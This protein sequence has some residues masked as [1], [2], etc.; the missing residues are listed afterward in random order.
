MVSLCVMGWGLVLLENSSVAAVAVAAAVTAAAVAAAAVA[1]GVDPPKTCVFRKEAKTY[2]TQSSFSHVQP[3][4]AEWHFF[5][6]TQTQH[7]KKRKLLA[8]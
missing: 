2:C 6:E 7:I 1:V 4:A 8:K 5:I 3:S